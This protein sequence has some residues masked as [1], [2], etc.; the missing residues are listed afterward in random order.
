MEVNLHVK[1][2]GNFK[3]VWQQAQPFCYKSSFPGCS[4]G[5][6]A[7]PVGTMVKN[8]SSN[9]ADAGDTSSI[10]RSGRSFEG[11]NGNPLWYSCL[12]NCMDRGALQNIVHRVTKSRTWL[13]DWTHTHLQVGRETGNNEKEKSHKIHS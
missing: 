4:A 7:F 13:S 3:V 8:P 2:C 1:N 11:G 5:K 12:E 6:G 10:P 9:A